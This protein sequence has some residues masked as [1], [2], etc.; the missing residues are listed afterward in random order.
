MEVIQS[1][2]C[3]RLVRK[4]DLVAQQVADNP[5]W[6]HWFYQDRNGLVLVVNGEVIGCGVTVTVLW[7]IDL[8]LV[9]CGW[10]RPLR[11]SLTEWGSEQSKDDTQEI[12]MS[13]GSR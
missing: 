1:N 4:E 2:P 6:N 3:I 12:R 8:F 11:A 9:A 7:L 10:V 5:L 13:I